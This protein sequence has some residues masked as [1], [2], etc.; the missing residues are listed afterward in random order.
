MPRTRFPALRH[1]ASLSAAVVAAALAQGALADEFFYDCAIDSK[2]SFLTQGTLI[3]APFSGTLIG[4]F[5]AKTNPTGTQTRPGLF[6]GSGNQPIPYTAS[7]A[8]DGVVESNPT[9]TFLAG[10]DLEALQV[11]I[12]GLEFD[13]LGGAEGVLPATVNIN[14]TTFRTFSP[15]SLFPGGVTIPVPIGDATIGELRAVQ[16]GDGVFG[17]LTEQKDGSYLFTAAVPVDLILSVEVLGAPVAESAVSP[18]V[19]PV[20]GRLVLT[21]AGIVFTLASSG[22]DSQTQPIEN[23]AF[24][25]IPL[26]LPTVLPTGGIA[27]LLIAG[28]VSAVT[29][30][31][32][33]DTEII[34][35]GTLREVV[36]DLDG[37]GAVDGTDLAILLGN[38]G[39]SGVGD[40]DGD[41]SVGG[42]DLS[43]LLNAWGS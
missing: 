15:N 42:G 3:S 36:G 43:L 11:R 39:K 21:K 12:I 9:G 41:G 24:S 6:G 1:A 25:D 33:L 17:S 19:L 29:I 32:A 34:A 16:T 31:S 14:Y 23:G 18:S 2:A 35:E 38:W 37:N 22:S 7:F 13:L 4:D 8:L 26:A 27:N 40:L 30:E 10:L 5:D 20:S 28:T